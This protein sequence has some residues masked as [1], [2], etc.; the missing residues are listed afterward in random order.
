M[1]VLPVPFPSL[2]SPSVRKVWIEILSLIITPS[3]FKVTFCEEGV[4][5][6]IVLRGITADGKSHLLWGR[7]GLKYQYPLQPENLEMSPS[8]R[9]VWIEM[10]GYA[11]S[12]PVLLVTFCEEGVDW[13]VN[14]PLYAW[15][16]F[17]S[18]SVR[19][20][21]IEMQDKYQGY[22]YTLSPS[23]RK[24]WIEIP[25]RY[26][27]HGGQAVTFCEETMLCSLIWAKNRRQ[28][29]ITSV[30]PNTEEPL[31]FKGCM[32]G[33]GWWMRYGKYR[34]NKNRYDRKTKED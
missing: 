22:G 2:A 4:D 5:W 3:R 33:S 23:V 18:P 10:L 32:T 24:V 25:R 7:C 31:I 15:Y 14:G 6:N 26:S 21:W 34:S 27:K 8:V 13:N 17:S 11:G 9:K 30:L 12:T 29:P 28:R 1:T 19:K 16:Q 20:V